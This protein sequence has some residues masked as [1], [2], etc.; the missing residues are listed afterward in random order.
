MCVQFLTGGILF[1]PAGQADAGSH[2][3]TAAAS[4]TA[5]ADAGDGRWQAWWWGADA[6]DDAWQTRLTSWPGRARNSQKDSGGGAEAEQPASRTASASDGTDQQPNAA[7]QHG[8]QRPGSHDG[9]TA[10]TDG[11]KQLGAAATKVSWRPN[12]GQAAE[13]ARPWRHAGGGRQPAGNGGGCRGRSRDAWPIKAA[14][15]AVRRAAFAGSQQT[16]SSKLHF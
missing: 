12:D 6:T 16:R 13:D 8:Q 3:T 11:P 4:A 7:K 2:A 1:K 14:V 5:H 10:R 9:T 15:P